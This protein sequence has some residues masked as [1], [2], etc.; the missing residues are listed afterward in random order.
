MR[1]SPARPLRVLLERPVREKLLRPVRERVVPEANPERVVPEEKRRVVPE[2]K[3]LREPRDSEREREAR[4]AERLRLTDER[5]R[6]A[7]PRL[8]LRLDERLER[9]KLR[10]EPRDE[11]RLGLREMLRPA[12]PREKL[13]LEPRETLRLEP[14]EKLRLPPPREALRPPPP[15]EPPPRENPPPRLPPRAHASGVA[16]MRKTRTGTQA[17]RFSRKNERISHLPCEE[18]LPVPNIRGRHDRRISKWGPVGVSGHRTLSLDPKV[19]PSVDPLP[20]EGS[21][22]APAR[23]GQRRSWPRI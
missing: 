6:P 14:R 16:T 4:A 22:P 1:E 20:V 2:E 15:R 10:L 18:T 21:H 7:A 23:V 17:I 8:K 12:E 9:E 5:L 13:R 19:S 3:R 11:L